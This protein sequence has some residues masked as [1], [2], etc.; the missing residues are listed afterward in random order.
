MAEN[1]QKGKYKPRNN[2]DQ[3]PTKWKYSPMYVDS[4]DATEQWE[5]G[6]VQSVESG[7]PFMDQDSRPNPQDEGENYVSPGSNGSLKIGKIRKKGMPK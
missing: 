7:D 1:K 4:D 6:D 5:M 2:K 3:V